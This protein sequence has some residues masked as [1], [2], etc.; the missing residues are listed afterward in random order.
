MV[1]NFYMQFHLSR[2]ISHR[3]SFAKGLLCSFTLALGWVAAM[4]QTQAAESVTIRLGPFQQSVAISDLEKFA[5]TGTLP[6]SL[7]TYASFLT[8]ETRELLNRQLQVDPKFADKFFNEIVTTPVGRQ[9]MS[10]L[11][12]AIPGSTTE[13]LQTALN[14]SLRQVNGLSVLSFLRAYPGESVTVDATQAVSLAVKFNPN[15]LQSQAFG[16]LL[17]RELQEKS[18]TRF[19]AAFD[20]ASPGKETVNQQ[21]FVLQD[22]ERNRRIAVDLYW[23]RGDSQQASQ[24]PLVVISHGFG[25]SR[26]SLEYLARHFASYGISVAAIEHPGS[27]YAAVA[28]AANAGN[29]NTILPATEFIDRPKDVSFLLNELAKL[30]TQPGQL[31]GKLNTDKVTVIG[32]SLGGYTGLALAGGEID[33]DNLRQFCKTSLSFSQSPGDWLQCSAASLKQDKL[34]LQDRRVKS[35]IALNPLVGRLFGKNGLSK[36][37]EP[38]LIVSGTEDGL[39]PALRHQIQPFNELRSNKYLLTAIGGTHLS[40]S[41]PAYLGSAATTIVKEKLGQETKNLRLLTQGVSL[42]FIKQLTPEAQNYKPFLTPAYAQSLSTPEIPLRL[43]TELPE[44]IKPW[45]NFTVKK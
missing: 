45:L 18:N 35:I 32:H 26:R 6:D 36:I 17:A 4:P 1:N 34:Q 40:I 13:T 25:A 27:N 11:E 15:Q 3:T 42:A 9:L 43:V 38:V 30:N 16:V 37:Q 22:G 12:A 14:L 31:Q 29:L 39:T 19:Q 20:A 7:K 23:S 2:L 28:Q 44:S 5:K 21:Q 41:D 10:S 8:P 33:L 24:Q